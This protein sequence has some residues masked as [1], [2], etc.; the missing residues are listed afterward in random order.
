MRQRHYH[1]RLAEIGYSERS[2]GGSAIDPLPEQTYAL[3]RRAVIGRRPIAAVYDRRPRLLCPHRLGWNNEGRPQVLCYQYG[4][5]SES[6]LGASGA[7]ENWR[8]LAVEKLLDVRLLEDRWRTAPNHTRPQ[9]CIVRVDVDAEDY[10]ERD[11]QNGQRGSS[12][13]KKRAIVMRIVAME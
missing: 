2:M 8:C 10:P 6:G 12:V 5:E 7:P 13:S 1:E 4:G 11:P 9:T 3:I